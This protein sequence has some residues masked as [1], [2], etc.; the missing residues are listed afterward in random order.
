MGAAV[1]FKDIQNFSYL[2]MVSAVGGYILLY[3]LFC[4][5]QT[6]A[7]VGGLFFY[8]LQ[9]NRNTDTV[10]EFTKGLMYNN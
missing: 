6:A 8:K 2:P 3:I 5:K 4:L 1:L 10:I 9:L 7:N